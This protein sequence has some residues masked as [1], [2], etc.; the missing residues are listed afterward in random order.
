MAKA[1]LEIGE[2]TEE[3]VKAKAEELRKEIFHLR[4]RNA[5]RQLDNPLTIRY[6]RRELARML[7]ALSEYRHGIRR[8]AGGEKKK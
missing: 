7:T 6:Q 2:M 4:F 5:M 1:K 3:E 8:L